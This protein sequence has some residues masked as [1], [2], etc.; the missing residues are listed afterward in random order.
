MIAGV[1]FGAVVGAMYA[2][3]PDVQEIEERLTTFVNG[4]EFKR[5]RFEFIRHDYN[6]GQRAGFFTKLA[7]SI[8]RGVFYGISLTRPA[9]ISDLEFLRVMG[10]L[11]EDI[12]IENT[13]VPFVTTAADLVNGG[14][15]VLDQGSLRRA[16]CATCAIPG[17][18]PPM[19][20]GERLLMDGGWVN[21]LPVE[22]LRR[23]GADF[24]IAINV[25]DSVLK[26]KE[27]NRGLELLLRADALVREQLMSHYVQ[28]ADVVVQPDVAGVHWA[29]F[30]RP[31]ELIQKGLEATTSSAGEIK[32]KIRWAKVRR[33]FL[34]NNK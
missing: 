9:Y 32:K 4:P 6:E 2:S 10:H 23:R 22:L 25:S 15:Y 33:M 11:I 17:I 29:D 13:Q 14:E 3:R 7:H 20:Y 34:G 12:D 19:D 27:I 5:T 1:S 28:K 26:V 16:V 30:S 31:R 21:P 18:F 24:V 8:K